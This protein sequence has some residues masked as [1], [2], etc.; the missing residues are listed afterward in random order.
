MKQDI[1]IITGNPNKVKDMSYLLG[2]ELSRSELDLVEI[3]STN[4]AEVAKHKA[5]DAYA[6]LQKPVLVDDTSLTFEHWG[7]LPGALI[8]YFMT[9]VG[10]DG[11]LEMLAGTTNRNCYM[12]CAIAYCDENG[13]RLFVGRVDGT[14]ATEQR[15]TNGWG[16]DTIF[17]PNG[18]TMTCAEMEGGKYWSYSARHRAV[19]ALKE[20]L[21]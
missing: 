10:C 7:T 9:E 12:E 20:G 5:I 2:R 14:V 15:G 17:I 21:R 8:K 4:A 1:T 18:E 16:Y 11:M 19:E 6:Q 13:P 3:Q